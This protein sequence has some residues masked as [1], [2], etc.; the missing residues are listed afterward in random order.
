MTEMDD[1]VR[2]VA[3]MI[4]GDVGSVNDTVMT[5]ASQ[6]IGHVLENRPLDDNDVEWLADWYPD[7]DPRELYEL[8][9]REFGGNVS[10]A[11]DHLQ[12]L[13]DSQSV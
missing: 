13:R 8:S 10:A 2:D 4:A 6:I 11:A 5:L 3:E 1:L 7:L 9:H 12:R